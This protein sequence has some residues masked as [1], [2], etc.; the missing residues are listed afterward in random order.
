[1]EAIVY[2]KAILLNVNWQLCS[3]VNRQNRKQL[4][5]NFFHTVIFN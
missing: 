4:K 3:K 2:F 1:M 5:R